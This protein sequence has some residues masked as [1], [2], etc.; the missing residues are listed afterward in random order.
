[1]CSNQLPT[2]EQLL[3]VQVV[4]RLEKLEKKVDNSQRTTVTVNPT[5]VVGVPSKPVYIYVK[6]KS[7][8]SRVKSQ[9]PPPDSNYGDEAKSSAEWHKWADRELAK[10]RKN[11]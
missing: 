7:A 10:L 11:N 9:S 1:M 8:K 5:K 3:Q 2:V 6:S 4:R